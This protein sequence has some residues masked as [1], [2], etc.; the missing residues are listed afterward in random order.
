MSKF[1]HRHWTR[2]TMESYL[3]SACLCSNDRL[4]FIPA[5]LSRYSAKLFFSLY[6]PAIRIYLNGLR[7][8]GGLRCGDYSALGCYNAY[9]FRERAL[10][11]VRSSMGDPAENC[12]RAKEHAV[13]PRD[14]DSPV[15]SSSGKVAPSVFIGPPRRRRRSVECEHSCV[16][17]P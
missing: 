12:S 5:R 14:P 10:N 16:V 3:L 6:D 15:Q 2:D 8:R 11:F 17:E 7:L 4:T 9:A 1:V 13:D